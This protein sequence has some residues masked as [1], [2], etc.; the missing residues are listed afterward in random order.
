MCWPRSF[1][2]MKTERENVIGSAVLTHRAQRIKTNQVPKIVRCNFPRC[3]EL[4]HI[5]SV[6][7]QQ[8]DSVCIVPSDL[9]EI[10]MSFQCECF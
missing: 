3:R 10:T 9:T 2:A 5:L 4:R 7:P 6:T 1:L 8:G